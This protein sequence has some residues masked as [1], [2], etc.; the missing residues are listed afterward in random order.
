[1]DYADSSVGAD[2]ASGSRRGLCLLVALWKQLF[3]WK[4]QSCLREKVAQCSCLSVATRIFG[5]GLHYLILRCTLQT[6]LLFLLRVDAACNTQQ[7]K[8][9]KSPLSTHTL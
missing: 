2:S 7:L 9:I 8:K 4:L 1:M 5:F 6:I 3:E